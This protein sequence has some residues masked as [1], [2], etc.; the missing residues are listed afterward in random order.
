MAGSTEAAGLHTGR[1]TRGR[2]LAAGGPD[3]GKGDTQR[4]FLLRSRLRGT[5]SRHK[6]DE[7]EAR[8]QM[9]AVLGEGG[10][11]STSLQFLCLVSALQ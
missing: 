7:K 11:S 5:F 3:G 4:R 1:P 8:K 2:R 9:M 6:S 10:S